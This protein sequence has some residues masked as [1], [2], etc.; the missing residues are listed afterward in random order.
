M[1]QCP[2]LVLAI[3]LWRGEKKGREMAPEGWGPLWSLLLLGY[4]LI[5]TVESA[6]ELH[7]VSVVLLTGSAITFCPCLSF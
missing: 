2:A 6:W 5:A 1:T 3:L 7:S 4:V